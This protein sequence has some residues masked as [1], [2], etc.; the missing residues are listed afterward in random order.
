[1]GHA[2][3][4]AAAENLVQVRRLAGEDVDAFVEVAVAG[5]LGDAGVTG[6]A[7]WTIL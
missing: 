4:S 2:L 1:M 6:E 3:A 5:C 7:Q